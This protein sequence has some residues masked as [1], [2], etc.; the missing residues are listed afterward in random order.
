M[1]NN[2]DNFEKSIKELFLIAKKDSEANTHTFKISL[3]GNVEMFENEL[4]EQSINVACKLGFIVKHFSVFADDSW[5]SV[6]IELVCINYID[7]YISELEK[8]IKLRDTPKMY[9]NALNK[10]IM[11][12]ENFNNKYGEGIDNRSAEITELEEILKLLQ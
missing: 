6:K 10:A 9:L 5:T 4:K 2:I 1:R 12:L 3:S 8:K 7:K 11:L